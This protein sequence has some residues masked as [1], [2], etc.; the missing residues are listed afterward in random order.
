MTVRAALPFV[1]T[2]PKEG[3]LMGLRRPHPA[4]R[5]DSPTSGLLICA[6]TKPALVALTNQFKNREIEKLYTATLNG[7]PEFY[8]EYQE[9]VQQSG[10]VELSDDM[11]WHTIDYKIEEKSAITLWRSTK[12]AHSS[13]ANNQCITQID[14]RPKTGRRH[15]IRRHMVSS[16]V[17]L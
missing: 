15:Q 3:T 13:R 9:S 2:Q 4:H 14:A 1:L 10:Q 7:L 5:I 16:I 6:K 8:K 12:I 17:N 11:I